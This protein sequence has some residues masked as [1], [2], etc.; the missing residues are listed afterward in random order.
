[1]DFVRSGVL[2]SSS[3]NGLPYRHC[4][5]TDVWSLHTK[6]SKRNT[7]RWRKKSLCF[8]NINLLGLLCSLVE[9]SVRQGAMGDAMIARASWVP[10]SAITLTLVKFLQSQCKHA[11]HARSASGLHHCWAKWSQRVQSSKTHKRMLAQYGED[12]TPRTV[13]E[14]V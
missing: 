2:I 11:Q 13:W 8:H 9:K 1:M 14:L 6:G 3:T 5:C 12:C 7:S 4:L 10:L